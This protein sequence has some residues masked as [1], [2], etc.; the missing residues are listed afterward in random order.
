MK[1]SNDMTI[2][3]A[4]DNVI[5]RRDRSF[6]YGFASCESNGFIPDF[7]NLQKNIAMFI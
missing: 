1:V 5:G 6:L 2:T 7:I 3:E 4:A